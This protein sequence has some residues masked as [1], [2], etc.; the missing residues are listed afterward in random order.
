MQFFSKKLLG[1]VLSSIGIAVALLCI[2]QTSLIKPYIRYG[3][4]YSHSKDSILNGPSIFSTNVPD[5]PLSSALH[6]FDLSKKDFAFAPETSLQ[7]HDTSRALPYCDLLDDCY[8]E[9]ATHLAIGDG[10]PFISSFEPLSE[11][12]AYAKVTPSFNPE[13]VL[14]LTDE[15]QIQGL[16]D[17]I[18]VETQKNSDSSTPLTLPSQLLQPLSPLSKPFDASKIPDQEQPTTVNPTPR[19]SSS[20][21]P[22]ELPLDSSTEPANSTPSD[23]TSPNNMLQR[24][25]RSTS[26]SPIPTLNI[27]E[28][29][30]PPE[31]QSQPVTA[32]AQTPA[33]VITAPVLEQ[34]APTIPTPSIPETS[35]SLLIPPVQPT[36]SPANPINSPDNSVKASPEGFLIK[37]N[38]ISIIEYIQFISGITKKNFIFNEDDLGFNVTIVSN[39]LTTVENIM[40]ALLQ[41]L[42]V[43]GLSL[44]EVDNNL[45]IHTNPSAN[46]PPKLQKDNPADTDLVTRVFRLANTSPEKMAQIILPLLS[47]LAL[48]SA[49]PESGGIIITDLTANVNKIAELIEELDS[50]KMA[51]DIG[52][53][54]LTNTPIDI[55][56]RIADRILAP[57]A[58][59]KVLVF[60]PDVNTN[61]I[62][63]VSSTAIVEKALDILS[64]IDVA[65]DKAP[66]DYNAE[67]GIEFDDGS[68]ASLSE[69]MAGYP[70]G[71]EEQDAEEYL[72]PAER[73]QMEALRKAILARGGQDALANAR[74]LSRRGIYERIKYFIQPIHHRSGALLQ[75]SLQRV[76]ESLAGA[77]LLHTNLKNDELIASLYNSQW[78]EETNSIVISGTVESIEGVRRIIEQI[79]T[80]IRQVFIEMLILE[81]TVNDSLNF[82]VD[83]ITD[84]SNPNS[85]G[86]Q[87]FTAASSPLESAIQTAVPPNAINV[88]SSGSTTTSQSVASSATTSST[89]SS[90]ITN[91]LIPDGIFSMGIIGRNIIHN[92][93][94]YGSLGILIQAL[95]QDTKTNIVMNPKIV[96][97]ENTT[98]ELFVGTNTRY[99]TQ[100]VA[101][102]F[103]TLLT[104]NYEY[105]DVGSTLRVTPRINNG[106]IITL[107][108][109][110]ELSSDVGG[111]GLAGSSGASSGSSN[112][113]VPAA[114]AAVID[115]GPVTRKSKTTTRIHVP[116]NYFVILSGMIQD[117]D[118]NVRAQVPCLGGIPLIGA[119][120]SQK[121]H[122][123]AK[124]NTMIFIRPHIVDNCEFNRITKRQQ[125]IFKQKAVVPKRWQREVDEALDFLNVKPNYDPEYQRW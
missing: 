107:D 49:M 7:L 104:T 114:T 56:A 116:D 35:P 32:P 70:T 112:T 105:R 51:L 4:L 6:H 34:N 45:I 44:I 60:T 68:S 111:N 46:A 72:S 108:I 64:E 19:K 120:F 21:L 93:T 39:E 41:E 83:W 76:A 99:R 62:F 81:T 77:D 82:G 5:L 92:G 10:T 22:S 123:D 85:A 73:A 121:R 42:R 78:I 122:T 91:G 3:T 40:T 90:T 89:T 87:G 75:E 101:N 63:I 125:D 54:V 102:N 61:S 13:T 88:L 8:H 28:T 84:F 15:E 118:T 109:E 33:P 106:N 96:V 12:T 115:A 86:V 69:S 16:K 27:E 20:T 74:M 66:A 79:D 17:L 59:G 2:S 25:P 48:V 50:S 18:P 43:H 11:T 38:N 36:H 47:N 57:I 67:E 53:Y 52:Q 124:R 117:E 30:I 9:Q 14:A 1:I 29:R 80:P 98:A 119:T 103:G 113:S 37:F 100:S 23:Q 58:Q 71:R 110:Q 24:A 31:I 95:H 26:P 55:A 97:E 65:R 94:S